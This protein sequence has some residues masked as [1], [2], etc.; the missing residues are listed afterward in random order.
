MKIFEA[1]ATVQHKAC[2]S[3]RRAIA[4]R[5]DLKPRRVWPH[6]QSPKHR[7]APDVPEPDVVAGVP[8][9]CWQ[10]APDS[11]VCDSRRRVSLIATTRTAPSAR[12]L[13]HD[14][15]ASS[16]SAVVLCWRMPGLQAR[17]R[18]SGRVFLGSWSGHGQWAQRPRCRL[19]RLLLLGPA[20]LRFVGGNPLG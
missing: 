5:A 11:G 8:E 15:S 18:H 14:P 19:C 13:S 1:H 3:C 7:Y 6:R 2:C 4:R 12:R 10:A 9:S 17:C 16:R 20:S